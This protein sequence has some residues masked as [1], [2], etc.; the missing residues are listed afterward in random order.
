MLVSVARGWRTNLWASHLKWHEQL[1]F[2]SILIMYRWSS[3]HAKFCWSSILW[4]RRVR[5]HER[6]WPRKQQTVACRRSSLRHRRWEPVRRRRCQ[7]SATTNTI[8]KEPKSEK[9]ARCGVW[10]LIWMTSEPS[11]LSPF[12]GFLLYYVTFIVGRNS[13]SGFCFRFV[14]LGRTSYSTKQL[15]DLFQVDLFSWTEQSVKTIPF[16]F[17]RG[18]GKFI[19]LLFRKKKI[20]SLIIYHWL[21]VPS[22]LFTCQH[23]PWIS[24]CC[25]GTFLIDC[26]F[27]SSITISQTSW[28][29]VSKRGH[30]DW[31]LEL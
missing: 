26:T 18:N 11:E 6:W 24:V 10:Q 13:L 23:F 5:L 19:K 16:F 30:R 22:V 29:T 7:I 27:N 15:N 17:S 21:S 8:W 3:S 28:L 31:A 25:R 9:N 14:P 1:S 20:S 2:G 4:S 12:P